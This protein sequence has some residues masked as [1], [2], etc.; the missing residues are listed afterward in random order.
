MIMF[1]NLQIKQKEKPTQTNIFGTR[2]LLTFSVEILEKHL[3][4]GVFIPFYS[5]K[6]LV[7]YKKRMRSAYRGNV[8]ITIK[9][10][11]IKYILRSLINLLMIWRVLNRLYCMVF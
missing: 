7:D 8:P 10:R 2:M 9:Q 4:K 3:D 6:E 1:Y 11:N 5:I